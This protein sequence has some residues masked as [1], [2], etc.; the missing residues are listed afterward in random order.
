MRYV[1]GKSEDELE[2]SVPRGRATGWI[3]RGGGKFVEGVGELGLHRAARG[4]NLTQ[5]VKQDASPASCEILTNPAVQ[6]SS[7]ALS[8]TKRAPEWEVA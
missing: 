4:S 8:S 7:G 6:F 3:L 1:V 5:V 2:R